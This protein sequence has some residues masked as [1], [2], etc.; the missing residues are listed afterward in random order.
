MMSVAEDADAGTRPVPASL[1]RYVRVLPE[2]G[3]V[4]DWPFAVNVPPPLKITD[5]NVNA[6]VDELL[7]PINAVTGLITLTPFTNREG[8]DTLPVADSV[9]AERE[10]ALSVPL[11]VAL[12]EPSSRTLRDVYTLLADTVRLLLKNRPVPGPMELADMSWLLSVSV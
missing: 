6:P 12:P 11:T 2:V 10:V 5:P 3:S 7:T 9:L 8:V 1:T 4:S